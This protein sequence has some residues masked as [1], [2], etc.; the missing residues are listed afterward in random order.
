MDPQCAKAREGL[1]DLLGGGAEEGAARE[2]RRHLATCE[3][4][5]AEADEMAEV[6]A[7]LDG[8]AAD[9]PLGGGVADPGREYWE[10]FAA[11]VVA[12][13]EGL[14]LARPAAGPP[15]RPARGRA[16]VIALR[17]PRD[18]LGWAL[19]GG[20]AAAAAAS[21]WL[22]LPG[23]SEGD[24]LRDPGPFAVEAPTRPSPEP[25]GG[26]ASAGGLDESDGLTDE[27]V[28]R[29]ERRIAE[30]ILPGE[31]SPPSP[32]AADPA[33]GAAVPDPDPPPGRAADGAA[34]RAAMPR[35]P[36]VVE[37]MGGGDVY[38][39]LQDLSEEEIERLLHRLEA[40]PG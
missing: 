39:A 11:R 36:F 28:A 26:V 15:V 20:V 27:D 8:D 38:D 32:P 29:I 24:G 25:P 30:V 18:P 31:P 21:L 23:A 34:G 22:A 16:A 13:G 33:G 14:G 19:A 10:G 9:G 17:W 3:A 2:A 37:E 7:Q 6:L 5:R 40:E 12:Q 4:C 35:S 1:V